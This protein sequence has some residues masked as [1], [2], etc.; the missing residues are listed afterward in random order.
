MFEPGVILSG[1]YEIIEQIGMGGMGAVYRA[2]ETDFDFDRS[3]AIKV[4]PP[5]LM[6]DEKL[7][8]RFHE[9]IKILAKLEHPNI[10]PV[11]AIGKENGCLFYVMKF[12]SGETLKAR[13]RRTGAL[14]SATVARVGTQLARA[15]DHIHRAGAI[16]RDIKSVNVMLDD[17]DNATLM[18]FGIAK[19]AGGANLT[20][21]G[22]V[23]GTA[24][25]MAPEQWEGKSDPRSDFYALG[26]MMYEALAGSPP[27]S[28]SSLSDIMAAHLRQQPPPLRTVR[29]QTSEPLAEVVHR[30][31]A[32]D[33]ADRYAT[34]ADL[35][36]ALEFVERSAP[37]AA[38]G[39]TAPAH[40]SVSVPALDST[41]GSLPSS[42]AIAATEESSTEAPAPAP[43]APSASDASPAAALTTVGPVA[44]AEKRRT[45]F[46]FGL[47]GGA[48]AL[49]VFL[50][51]VA[52]G[53][54]GGETLS[55][56]FTGWGNHFYATQNYG[57][58]PLFNAVT[59]YE[60]ALFYD[61]RNPAALKARRSAAENLAAMG[62]SYARTDA[63][64][65][66]KYL[67][68]ALE[69]EPDPNWA[70][71]YHKIQEGRR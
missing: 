59:C 40:V 58:P 22:E 10:V 6:T 66:A 23:L 71:R 29:P 15:I 56:F 49:L 18:D 50:G 64:L 9:E 28:G 39:R 38:P 43:P 62:E 69:L 19:I 53:I 20:A 63:V 11:Y 30:C 14:A 61:P 45:G 25:Y 13:L 68:W 42:A 17:Q 44:P 1:K 16:H 48:A 3:V 65:A 36:A 26:V 7:V 27:F 54:L 70:K 21:A 12:L 24:P 55:E 51:L 47:V 52:G 33:P 37:P 4:L 2:R 34:A 57:S 32:K 35:V 41:T 60:L 67:Q 8:Q 46:L 5:H 31:L